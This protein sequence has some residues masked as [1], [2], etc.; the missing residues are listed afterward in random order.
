MRFV[1]GNHAKSGWNDLYVGPGGTFN[2]EVHSDGFENPS[3]VV[4]ASGVVGE[5]ELNLSAKGPAAV[6]FWSHKDFGGAPNGPF[7][8]GTTNVFGGQ[9]NQT[10]LWLSRFLPDPG[11][12]LLLPDRL[13]FTNTNA[14][15]VMGI[16]KDEDPVSAAGS[17]VSA[18]LMGD[19]IVKANEINVTRGAALAP[20]G[21]TSAGRYVAGTLTLDAPTINLDG[22]ALLY[23]AYGPQ[24]GLTFDSGGI[25]DSNNT[26]LN[27]VV[28]AVNMDKGMVN[29]VSAA[30]SMFGASP[31]LVIR[32]DN[33]FDGIADDGALNDRLTAAVSG[34]A[35]VRT[36]GGPRGGY[37][38]QFGG[39]PALGTGAK[40]AGTDNIWL[41]FG[42]GGDGLHSLTMEW[43]GRGDPD[44]PMDGVWTSGPLFESLQQGTP[45]HEN[46]FLPG[47]KV[48]IFT[49]DTF[50]I[51]L[52][53]LNRDIAPAGIVVSG[54]VVGQDFTGGDGYSGHYTLWGPG[55]IT[56][57]AGSAFGK[58]A[59]HDLSV[60][61]DEWLVATGKLE[62]FGDS[63]LTLLN[64]GGNDFRDG[65]DLWRGAMEF[66]RANQLGDG[67][68]GIHFLDNATLRALVDTEVPLA[69]D[70]TIADGATGSLGANAGVTFA[71]AGNM[72]GT[73]AAT[74]DKSGAGTVI[75]G[76][77]PLDPTPSGFKGLVTVSEGTL[78][79]VGNYG[80]T[81]G[82][83]VKA[84]ATLSGT[85]TIGGLAI[86]RSPN[87]PI[88]GTL[89]P[90]NLSAFVN[91]AT[92]PVEAPLSFL[93]GLTRRT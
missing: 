58:Y 50:A 23:T 77:T 28:G 45:G 88:G 83:D 64:T 41:V 10:I 76:K 51:G 57:N 40:T 80:G 90:D 52:V 82:I 73:T 78:R 13:C 42:D 2:L 22:F 32:S 15:N 35:L 21:I 19:G 84:G 65:I 55:G 39:D 4:F 9:E 6:E 37:S 63:I 85:G 12:P 74:L 1:T 79:V 70:I 8:M 20:V 62:K 44:H 17:L 67:G 11:N 24:E 89:K 61:P 27:L 53:E 38:F 30:G 48:H 31:L 75:L 91:A 29:F 5:G 93:D 56:A 54:L 3:L 46:Q 71:Y 66:D 86:V 25:P 14:F 7:G 81:A 87:S 49:D 59:D 26:L 47:D 16:G 36:T 68:N 60:D 92:A 34:F 18:G 33:G 69:N 72:T 43:T